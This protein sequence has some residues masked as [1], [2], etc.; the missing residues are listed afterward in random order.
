MF[1]VCQLNASPGDLPSRLVIC[2]LV[3]TNRSTPKFLKILNGR[4]NTNRLG[5]YVNITNIKNKC[6]II[7][8]VVTILYSSFILSSPGKG[9]WV[10]PRYVQVPRARC[11]FQH[12]DHSFQFVVVSNT[13]CQM[14]QNQN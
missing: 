1:K 3:S 12:I 13:L 9:K 4:I 8:I 10:F 11:A 6:K 14:V 2:I 5:I 7:T